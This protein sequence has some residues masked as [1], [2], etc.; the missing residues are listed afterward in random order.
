MQRPP[1]LLPPGGT[2]AR[3]R[4][5]GI[6]S[7]DARRE[8]PPHPGRRPRPHAGGLLAPR[9]RPRAAAR[10]LAGRGRLGL[11]VLVAFEG[12]W[13]LGRRVGRSR[14]SSLLAGA[15]FAWGGGLLSWGLFPRTAAAAWVPWLAT[16]VL[17]LFR[18]P[19]RRSL[20]TTAAIT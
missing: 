3:V 7:A 13:L 6:E 5:S 11:K 8:A 14:G 10:P 4:G 18:R 15:G 16:G 17:G 19:T 12:T 9:P 2:R 1:N 20:A